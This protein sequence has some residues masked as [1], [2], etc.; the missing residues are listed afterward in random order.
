MFLVSIPVRGS[1]N[2]KPIK[3]EPSGTIYIQFPSPLGEVVMESEKIFR[4]KQKDASYVSI[5]VRGSGNGK[6]NCR[7]VRNFYG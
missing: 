1:G 5:P 7:A 3:N 6:G 2:G 4:V